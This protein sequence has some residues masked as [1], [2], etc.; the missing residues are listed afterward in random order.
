MHPWL[1]R[2]LQWAYVASHAPKFFFVVLRS[3]L[4]GDGRA[5]RALAWINS[6]NCE[7]PGIGVSRGTTRLPQQDAALIFY[8]WDHSYFSGKVRG[9]LRHKQRRCS[10]LQFTEVTATP[11]MCRA[12]SAA[13]RSGAVP[14]LGLPDGRVIQDS[15]QIIDAVEQLHPAPAM[16]PGLDRPR[17][18]LACQLLELWGD[19][20]MLVPA[21]HYRWAYAGDGSAA[22]DMPRTLD[23]N[24]AEWNRLQWGQ[25]LCPEGDETEQSETGRWLVDNVML[26]G[27][28]AKGGMEVRRTVSC[29]GIPG[30]LSLG[31]HR[32]SGSHGA[33]WLRGRLH[34]DASSLYSRLPAYPLHNVRSIE[35]DALNRIV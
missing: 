3:L 21:Y 31:M 7:R 5:T 15:S 26:T 13:T 32:R 17:Q 18:R 1:N 9:Y 6:V 19:E 35:S 14:Q 25:F 20:W 16:L 34:A 27:L 4:R 33:L 29:V 10:Q 12:L 30:R 8:A 22:Q 23:E 2:L 28:G 11:D 24:H